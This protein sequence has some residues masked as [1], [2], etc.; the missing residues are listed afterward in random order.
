MTDDASTVGAL[1]LRISS[2]TRQ[3]G[4]IDHNLTLYP[5]LTSLPFSDTTRAAFVHRKRAIVLMMIVQG[6]LQLRGMAMV[7]F[8][9]LGNICDRMGVDDNRETFK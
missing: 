2:Q 7:L 4:A 8:L 6:H 1:L 3:T 9:T 5:G